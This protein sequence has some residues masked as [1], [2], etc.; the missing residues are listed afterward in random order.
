MLDWQDLIKFKVKWGLES[1]KFIGEAENIN[2]KSEPSK[3]NQ[4]KP[5]AWWYWIS[6]VYLLIQSIVSM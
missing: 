3:N 4:N 6:Y 2:G 1:L 5:N